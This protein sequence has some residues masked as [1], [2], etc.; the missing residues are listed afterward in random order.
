MKEKFFLF[1]GIIISIFSV[2]L[3]ISY[4]R[5]E[6]RM[7]GFHANDN[8]AWILLIFGVAMIAY[9]IGRNEKDT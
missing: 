1:V 2:I 8:L 5:M 4:A 7:K 6:I 9:F 3:L